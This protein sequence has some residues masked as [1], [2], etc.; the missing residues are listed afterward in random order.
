M[1]SESDVVEK[2]NNEDI[3]LVRLIWVDNAGIERAY[4]VS[5]D[6]IEST[7]ENGVNIPPIQ[8]TFTDFDI[9]TMEGPY[10][11]TGEVRKVPDSESFR[12][13]PYAERTAA[14]LCNIYELD[15]TPWDAD[16]RSSL[17]TFLDDFEYTLNAAFEPEWYMLK[18]QDGELVPADESGCFAVDGHQS[19]HEIILDIVDALKEQ[20]MNLSVYYPEYGPGQQEVVIDHAK[21]L[22]AADNQTF[23]KQTVKSVV[24]QHGLK[25][26]FVP[27][28]LADGPGS[29]CHIHI[30]LWDEDE[31]VFYDGK[32]S[33]YGLSDKG[34]HFVGGLLE[35]AP[36]LVALTAPSIMSYKRLQPHM[37]AS[38]YTAWGPD[39]R[40]AVVRVPS[41]NW[42][43]PS[44][45]TRVEWKA[46][47]NMANPYLAL[48]GILAAGADGIERELEPGKPA[49][50]DPDLLSEKER[51]G[52]GIDRLPETLGEA[53]DQLESDEVLKDTLGEEL[54]ES[55]AAAKRAVWDE[56]TSETTEWEIGRYTQ[57]Y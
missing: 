1:L 29:G 41:S 36:A 14:M 17:K 33:P 6:R 57:Y 22:R 18:E 40:E 26:S 10:G 5:A 55:Y 15:Q 28:P 12:K 48:L 50:K 27:K 52:R 31:N 7:F 53:L 13:L 45:T 16:P 8:Q 11:A 56:F 34:R 49:E 4:S 39:N 19:A 25:A 51:K 43:E 44:K 30:S 46:A 2:C 54:F 42:G 32:G 9:P 3:E 23:Y 21:G 38:A 37:W 20:G 24:K 47:D 35:H